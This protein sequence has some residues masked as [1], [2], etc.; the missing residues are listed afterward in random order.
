MTK[1]M[2]FLQNRGIALITGASSGLGETFARYLGRSGFSLI[3]VAR[4]QEKLSRLAEG[5]RED[6]DVKVDVVSAGKFRDRLKIFD[7]TIYSMWLDENS[8]VGYGY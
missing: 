5:L 7:K 8:E 4:R 3:L 2:T 1:K 6:F